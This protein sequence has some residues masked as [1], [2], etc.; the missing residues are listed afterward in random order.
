MELCQ[1]RFKLGK[2]FGLWNVVA[3]RQ[4]WHGGVGISSDFRW[5][6]MALEVDRAI[7]TS[8]Y[9][10]YVVELLATLLMVAEW[11]IGG[12]VWLTGGRGW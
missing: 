6:M 3:P 1:F 10:G 12:N 2:E 7:L 11:E 9:G 8:N 5:E 4:W